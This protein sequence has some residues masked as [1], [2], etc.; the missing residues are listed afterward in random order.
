MNNASIKSILKKSNNLNSSWQQIKQNI[1]NNQFKDMNNR[2]SSL[3]DMYLDL[4]LN[5]EKKSDLNNS[6]NLLNFP[7]IL[8]TS[9]RHNLIS[10]PSSEV[11]DDKYHDVISLNVD[12]STEDQVLSKQEENSFHLNPNKLSLELSFSSSDSSSVM[13][14][15]SSTTSITYYDDFY[16][17]S[18]VNRQTIKLPEYQKLTKSDICFKK[19]ANANQNLSHSFSSFSSNS[20]HEIKPVENYFNTDSQ[21]YE[22]FNMINQLNRKTKFRAEQ[23]WKRKEQLINKT[24]IYP[25]MEN[26]E[27]NINIL[28]DFLLIC[29]FSK[30]STIEMLRLQFVCKRWHG[31]IWCTEYTYKLFRSID[32]KSDCLIKPKSV[33]NSEPVIKNLT[34]TRF[35]RLKPQKLTK[36]KSLNWN[37]KSAKTV[38][39]DL[40]IKF[41]LTK[42]INRQTYPLCLCVERIRIRNTNRLSDRGLELIAGLCPEL[43]QLIIRNCLSIRSTS[44]E[45]IID[46]CENLK[47]LDLTGC[48]NL[49]NL[50]FGDKKPTKKSLNDLYRK[51]LGNKK[52]EECE[53]KQS[54]EKFNINEYLYLQHVDLSFCSNINDKSLEYLCKTCIYIRNLYLRRCK[55]ITDIGVLYIAKYCVHLRELSLCQCVKVSDTGIRYLAKDKNLYS[56]SKNSIGEAPEC[57][58]NNGPREYKLKYLSLAECPLIT[59]Y[60][61]IYL[62]K[63]GFF[64]QIKYL[65]LRG[66]SKITDKFIKYMVGANFI[67]R[68]IQDELM[69]SSLSKIQHKFFIPLELRTID[70]SKCSISDKSIEYLCRLA[71]LKPDS[72]KRISLRYCDG[73]TDIGI[74]NIAANCR[75]LQ[76]LN[77]TKCANVS[78]QSLREIKKNCPSCVIQHTNFSFC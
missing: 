20:L 71:I 57:R 75:N 22:N 74:R 13:T 38:N 36:T 30:L 37:H 49:T 76:S 43:R 58:T 56:S 66:C 40:V 31:I 48:F 65:N 35:F 26:Q 18:K 15:V 23:N 55:Q 12:F 51:I 64:Q 44:V 45:K 52:L 47:Y 54:I 5:N 1:E 32:I 9:F 59:D 2:Y 46:N 29:I 4:A 34:F 61:L 39:V 67:A 77:V 11:Y 62:C 63:V 60:S 8:E 28:D 78:S 70:L 6:L 72:L 7:D 33:P 25:K 24:K 21:L 69:V 50:A 3:A 16:V 41:L 73:I 42:L 27:I 53:R 68:F 17:S 19:K 10:E 14:N